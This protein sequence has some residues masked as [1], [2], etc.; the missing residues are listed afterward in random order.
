MESKKI[1][2]FKEFLKEQSIKKDTKIDKN[3]KLKVKLNEK[4]NV[5]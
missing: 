1:G 5:K 4:Y 2:T 3:T